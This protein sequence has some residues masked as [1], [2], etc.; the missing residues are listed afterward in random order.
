MTSLHKQTGRS[1]IHQL[2]L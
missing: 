2:Q 1:N